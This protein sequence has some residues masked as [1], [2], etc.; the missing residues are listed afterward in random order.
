MVDFQWTL[1]CFQFNQFLK[2]NV[3]RYTDFQELVYTDFVD[4]LIF[5]VHV[6]QFVFSVHQFLKISV[7]RYID[8]LSTN[9][10]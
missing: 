6:H 5:D 4:W 8:F 7:S 2:I 1:V 10:T 3:S 9:H